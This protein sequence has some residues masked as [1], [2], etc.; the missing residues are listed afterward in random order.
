MSGPSVALIADPTSP[1]GCREYLAE[2]VE[3][4]T[5]APPCRIDSRH[6]AACGT[7]RVRERDG[8]RLRLHVPEQGV[9]VVPDVVVL[10]EIPPHRRRSLAAFQRLLAHHRTVTL[11]AGVAAWRAATEKD[12]TLAYFRRDGVAHMDTVVLSRPGA[13]EADAAFERLGGDVWARPVVGT[14]GSDTFHVTTGTQLADAT[15]YYARR[16]SAWLL[17]RDAGNTVADGRR[18]Q[19][20]VFVLGG[21]VI[22]AREH[23]QAAT[24]A[25]CNTCQGATAVPIAPADLPRASPTWPSRPPRRW[26]CPSPEWTWRSRTA[27]SSSR[28][29][30]SR[31]SS[32]ASWRRWP[33]RTSRPTW[34]PSTAPRRAA[35]AATAA[36]HTACATAAGSTGPHPKWPRAP[37]PG[38][39][40]P[41]E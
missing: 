19:F 13:R 31:P 26:A 20:R 30:S 18:H 35:G 9:E 21:R 33:C 38:R 12:R 40:G 10:Y 3:V 39:V 22:H 16:H 11:G 29:T 6:F 8:T 14:G 17:S 4:L 24:D 1:E 5:G 36:R 7:G 32:T 41:E 25:P 23:L 2:A 27:G 37:R 34:T 15:A 28:S